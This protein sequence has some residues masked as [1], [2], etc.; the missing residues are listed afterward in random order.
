MLGKIGT[1][2]QMLLAQDQVLLLL[3]WSNP[4]ARNEGRSSKTEENCD[5]TCAGA[6]LSHEMR[7]DRPKLRKKCDFTSA[8][9]TLSHEMR[10]DRQ[11]LG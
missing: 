5:F 9:A 7:V 11:K 2:N 1:P 3:C 8:G 4:F 10:V 6:T